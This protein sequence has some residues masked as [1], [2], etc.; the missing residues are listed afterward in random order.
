LILESLVKFSELPVSCK[1]RLL[2]EKEQTKA[3]IE[4]IQ[5]TGIKFFTIHLRIKDQPPQFKANWK[6]IHD[7]V[8]IFF[9][10]EKLCENTLQY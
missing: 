7:I 8:K 2:E 10:L 4:T 6:A 5:S 1:I 3:F 9:I